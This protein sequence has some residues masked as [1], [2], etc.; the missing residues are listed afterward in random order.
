MAVPDS[1][2]NAFRPRTS[3]S[4][5][6]TVLRSAL[7]PVAIL[8]IIHRSYVL[9][10]NG[11]I[12]DD[13]GPVYRAVVNFKMG[14]D[15]YNE[16]FDYVDPHYLY[17][18]GGTLL[19]APF[20]YL[21]VDASRYWFIFFNS[22][23]ILLAAYFLLRLFKFSLSSVAAPAL[24]LAMFCTESVTNTL[25]FT[26]INGCILLCEV[27]FFRWLLDGKVNHQWWA[28][29]AVGLTLVIKPSLLP[30]LLLPLLNR[31]WRALVPAIGV[32]LL[33]N[34]AA[35]P[36]VSDPMNFVRGTVPYIFATRDYF[37]SSILGNGIYYGLPMWLI[38]LLR[39]VFGLL[40]VGSLWLL[41]RYY[42]ER[43]PLFWMLTSSGVLL[44]ATF[45]VTALGQGY[46]SMMLFPF[47]MTVVL[48]NSVIRNW[49]AWLA[50]YGFMTMDRW[51]LGHWPTTGRAL[52]YLRITYGWSLMLIV[53]F[54]V[55]YYRYL[56]AKADGRLDEGIDP[57]WLT[58]DRQRASV[59]P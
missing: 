11:Y 54:C 18:P 28:G 27:L 24:L 41:Y 44:I 36:L 34:A 37:N 7:W 15:I 35:W 43:D 52:E 49:V 55:L 1:L 9:A 19:L 58:P 12:T 59:E 50:I 29:V 22:V 31:Q 56:D 26:N 46:Y 23:A 14:W 30:L 17:P 5:A 39:I 25:V 45:L 57:Q 51:L 2:L 16:H 4:T 48:A 6:A 42:R 21:P 8:S 10:T 20:G 40:A 53:V 32:P 33:F 47:L 38:L 3:P 13:F